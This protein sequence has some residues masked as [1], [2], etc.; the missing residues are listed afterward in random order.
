MTNSDISV[1]VVDRCQNAV[2]PTKSLCGGKVAIKNAICAVCKA[3]CQPIFS[4]EKGFGIKHF[5]SMRCFAKSH[6]MKN[7]P[8]T[9]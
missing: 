4:V 9:I 7:E 2:V 8:G 5:C 6:Q 3:A 1:V